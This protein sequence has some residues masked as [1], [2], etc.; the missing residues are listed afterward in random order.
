M[1]KICQ[2]CG[3]KFQCLGTEKCWCNFIKI[4]DEKLEHLKLY[5]DDCFCEKCLL[6]NTDIK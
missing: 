6:T 4:A 3:K 1:D 2:K 5:S